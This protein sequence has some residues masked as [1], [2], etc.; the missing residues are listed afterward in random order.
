MGS[1][2]PASATPME[3]RSNRVPRRRAESTPI[4]TPPISQSTDAPIA[5]DRV[6]GRSLIICG[7]TGSW[8]R[9]E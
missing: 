6:T 1:D 8:L 7:H 5:S 3:K 2:T 4:A 9:N